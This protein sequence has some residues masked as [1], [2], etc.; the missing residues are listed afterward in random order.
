MGMKHAALE[1]I[2]AFEIW[3]IRRREMPGANDHMIE[4]FGIIAVVWQVAD[5]NGKL[6][7][8]GFYVA[9][10]GIEADPVPHA[11]LFNAPFDIVE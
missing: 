10:G 7:T 9:Y 3:H 8:F 11:G 5:R 4:L 1:R 6:I 2:K